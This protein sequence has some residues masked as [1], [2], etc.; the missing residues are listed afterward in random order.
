MDDIDF[1]IVAIS[2]TLEDILQCNEAKPNTMYERI[3]E[4]L[5]GVQQALYSYR[6]VSTT[7]PSSKR[8]NLGDE[9]T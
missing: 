6:A 4:E 7:P 1:N 5:K 8:T 3:E 2:D 9:P